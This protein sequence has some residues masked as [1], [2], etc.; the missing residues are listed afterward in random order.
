MNVSRI[1]RFLDSAS[2][3]PGQPVVQRTYA[4][5]PTVWVSAGS[6]QAA[7]YEMA[8]A[9]AR[10]QVAERQWQQLLAEQPF[11]CN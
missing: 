10:R 8:Y 2:R 11:Q 4:A 6:V 1:T 7:I 5:V 9:A 3:L